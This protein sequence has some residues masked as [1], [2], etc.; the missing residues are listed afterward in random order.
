MRQYMKSGSGK[1]ARVP[2]E[3][4]WA[5]SLDP[6][7]ASGWA[8]WNENELVE[9]GIAR[10]NDLI[11]L[12]DSFAWGRLKHI[13]YED[14]RLQKGRALQQAGSHMIASQVIGMAKLHAR[15]TNASLWPQEVSCLTMA[16]LHSGILRP[17][18]HSKTHDIDAVLHGFWWLES[19][20]RQPQ[21][22]TV[23][24]RPVRS[25]PLA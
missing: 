6:G 11:D 18:D 8:L 24:S 21:V 10:E 12:F 23:L 1:T 25:S 14:W 3:I 15:Q 9:M 19:M 4:G 7:D 5:L 20:G 16:M 13:V 2:T 22:D 17:A